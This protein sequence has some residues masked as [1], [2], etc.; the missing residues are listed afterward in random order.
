V[1]GASWSA[2]TSE[3]VDSS[4]AYCQRL[5]PRCVFQVDRR[6]LSAFAA[7]AVPPETSRKAAHS[8][9]QVSSAM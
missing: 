3:L 1:T 5:V 9:V 7:V 6:W 8:G 4:S 2:T